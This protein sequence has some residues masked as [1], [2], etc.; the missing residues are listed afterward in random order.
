[1]RNIFDFFLG[2]WS[3]KR[4]IKNNLGNSVIAHG[5]AE[6]SRMLLDQTQ[7]HYHEQVRVE[8]Q[9][10]STQQA[11][12]HSLPA[13]QNYHYEITADH[14]GFKISVRFP[15]TQ[16]IFHQLII[17]NNLSAVHLPLICVATPHLCGQDNYATTYFLMSDNVFKIKYEVFGPR[18]NYRSNTVFERLG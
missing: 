10:N 4:S 11:A 5:S 16:V 18:K 12:H 7:L 2:K 17:P 9:P 1:M 14:G 8:I 3:L 15:E 6:F 13:T